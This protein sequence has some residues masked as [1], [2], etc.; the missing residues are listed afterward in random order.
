MNNIISSDWLE[1]D[2][3]NDSSNKLYK[4]EVQKDRQADGQIVGWVETH[5]EPDRKR[6]KTAIQKNI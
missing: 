2:K 5:G 4:Q 6:K 1:V 3:Q